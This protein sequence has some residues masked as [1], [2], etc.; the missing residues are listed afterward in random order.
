MIDHGNAVDFRLCPKEALGTVG[1]I[2]VIVV[3]LGAVAFYD[4][5]G[6]GLAL[7]CMVGVLFI[8]FFA[9]GYLIARFDRSVKLRIDVNGVHSA[10]LFV[11]SVPWS[12]I[13]HI[14]FVRF[15]RGTL[16]MKVFVGPPR[17]PWQALGFES[18]AMLFQRGRINLEVEDLEGEVDDIIAAIRRF[19]PQTTVGF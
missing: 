13:S 14:A 15:P 4:R 12:H 19:S 1:M 3:L 9:L 10:K 11:R 8:G 16:K 7:A 2:L 18:F 17:G 6:V 5:G